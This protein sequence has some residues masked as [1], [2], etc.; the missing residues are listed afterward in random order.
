MSNCILC[1]RKCHVDR[2]LDQRGYCNAPAKIT[3]ARAA[4]HFW[5]EPCISGT[6][7]SGAVFFSG[8]NMGCIFCQNQEISHGNVAME[9]S[10][11]RLSDIFL[12]L[13]TQGA[14]NINLVTPSHYVPQ[15]ANALES[16]KNKGLKIPVLYNTSSYE[17][18]STLKLLDGLIDIY[19]PDFKYYSEDLSLQLSNAPKYSE[20]ALKAIDEML[21]QVGEPVFLEDNHLISSFDYNEI[22]SNISDED[23]YAGP[24]MQRGVI[25]RHLLLPGQIE[26]SKRVISSLL[27]H[28][29]DKVFISLMGQ[30]TPMEHIKSLTDTSKLSFLKRTVSEHEYDELL[31]YAIDCGLE[32]GFM[33]SLDTSSESFIPAFDYKGL[34]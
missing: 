28:F 9:I 14:H 27:K 11:S 10:V 3:A 18:A 30:Y 26:D 5:E 25:V 13:E 24:L 22:I 15:I 17:E 12:E 34:K 32:N 31:D 6:K 19:L 29:G 21:R 8:C 20:I 7:G 1:P 2:T 16:A 33:Q 23:D 4:L